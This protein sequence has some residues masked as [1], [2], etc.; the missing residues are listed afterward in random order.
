MKN[1]FLLDDNTDLDSFSQMISSKYGH[2]RIKTI[3]ESIEEANIANRQ[4][5]DVFI[6]RENY[7]TI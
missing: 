3:D 7:S 1:V 5:A 6:V 2:L 4:D